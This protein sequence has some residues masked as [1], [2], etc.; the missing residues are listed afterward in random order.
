MKLSKRI[1][2]GIAGIAAVIILGVAILPVAAH[3]SFA[4]YDTAVEKTLTG[5][6]ERFIIG[7]NHSQYVMRVVSPDGKEQVDDK[8]KPVIWTIETTSAAQLSQLN[9]TVETFKIGTIFTATF[10]PLRDGRNGG[11]QRGTAII[12]CGMT[13]PAGGCTETTGKKYGR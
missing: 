2:G 4:M 6:L 10:S 13:M 12:M 8:G 3:H 1:S 5:K 9:I 11:A 7:A